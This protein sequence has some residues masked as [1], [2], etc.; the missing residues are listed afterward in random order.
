MEIGFTGT[1]SGMTE[2]QRKTLRRILRGQVGGFH[3]GDC[4]GADAEAHDIADAAGLSVHI[5]PPT[6]PAKRAFKNTQPDRVRPEK[7]YLDRNKD[8]VRDTEALVAA[9]GAPVEQLRSG[10]WST[11]RFARR[12]KR[13]IAIVLPDGSIRRF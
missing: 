13:P 3:H 2:P 10:T 7:P 1:Q 9:P 11:V 12:L 6:N 8:I 5:H 4:I